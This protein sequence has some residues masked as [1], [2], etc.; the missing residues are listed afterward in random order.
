MKYLAVTL[1]KKVK[2][3]YDKNLKK[4]KISDD[5]KISNFHG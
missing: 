3:F 2:E 1:T 5:E 4:E